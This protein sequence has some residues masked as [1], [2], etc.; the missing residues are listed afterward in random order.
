MFFN[1]K[2]KVK[3]IEWIHGIIKVLAFFLMLGFVYSCGSE[4][5]VSD[6]PTAPDITSITPNRGPV[7]TS[8]M[9][10]GSGFN[11]I[12]SENAVTFN[13]EEA[14]VTD[15]T[16]TTIEVFVPE[17]ATTGPVAVVVDGETATGPVFTVEGGMP[18][19][20]AIEPDSGIVG[21]EVTIRGMNFSSTPSENTITFNGTNAPVNQASDTLLVTEVPAVA[22][23]GP[24]EVTVDGETT[25]GP[26]FTV[27]TQGTLEVLVST[28]GPDPDA[29][30]YTLT[31]DGTDS[32]NSEPADTLFFTGL[33]EG[34]HNVEM[35]DVASNCSVSGNNPRTITIS[36]GDTTSTAFS[37]ICQTILNNQI[38]FTSDRDGNDEIYVMDNTGANQTRITNNT[39]GDDDPAI[40]PDGTQIAFTSDRD[41]NSE[42]F[43]MNADGS[44]VEQITITSGVENSAPTWSP[45]GSQLAFTRFK[46]SQV[47]DV[48]VINADGSNEFNVT[49]TDSSN[50]SGPEWSP[51]GNQLAF[52]SDRGPEGDTEVW[53]VNPDGSG[54][55]QLTNND[56]MMADG[57]PD[58]SPDGTQIAFTTNRDDQDFEIYIMNADG[59]SQTRLTNTAGQDLQPS[60]S[61]DGGQ[62]IFF[63]TRV[64]N[65]EIYRINVDGSGVTNLTLNT[66]NEIDPDW[67]PVE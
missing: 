46:G 58:W 29:D 25:T 56:D 1:I 14:D 7:G 18:G 33:D 28:S 60:W 10:E 40:S 42:I 44:N 19:I 57:Q 54:L 20:A 5:G 67:S 27:I 26:D 55:T 6:P 65:G 22:T 9:L 23:T 39:A 35:T 32:Q 53:L 52:T 50:D 3:G 51:D 34:S 17:A 49:Q 31:V 4:E 59:T 21:T 47:F 30:G 48:F 13:G 66:A 38:V 24:V 16:P 41:G 11:P 36:A 61:P 12:A 15:A 8:V 43:I 2:L 62:I 45:D 37:V 64:N 63:S